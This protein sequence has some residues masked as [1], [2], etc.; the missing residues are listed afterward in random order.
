MKR[1]AVFTLAAAALVIFLSA[2]KSNLSA[3]ASAPSGP[4]RTI[5]P[6][7]TGRFGL[8]QIIDDYGHADDGSILG[9]LS[10]AQIQTEAPHYDSVWASFNPNAWN[11]SHRGMIVSRYTIPNEDNELIS[12]R[13]LVWWQKNRP[14]WV[15][16]A[17]DAR[18]NPTRASPW[19]GVGFSDVPLD[20]H[21]PAVVRYQAHQ[22]GD[23]MIAHGYN[24]LAV[25]NF[26]FANYMRAPN[27]LLGQG[28][29]RPGWYACGIY[30]DGRFVR[31]YGSAGSSDF[32]RADP[33]WITDL[34]NWIA[35]TRK[36]FDSDPKLV[37]HH[38]KVLVNHPILGDT[39]NS[40]EQQMLRSVDGVLIENGFTK[41]GQYVNPQSRSLPTLLRRTLSWMQA[42]QSAHTAVFVIDYFCKGGVTVSGAACSYDPS[43]LSPSQ[44]DWA[45]ATYAIANNGGAGVYIAPQ[46]GDNYSYRAEY[47]HVYGAP[48]GDVEQA[49]AV[50]TRRFQNGMAIVNASYRAQAVSLPTNHTYTDIEGRA[51][52]N[53][54]TVNGADGYM[55]LTSANGCL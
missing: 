41:Y 49:G 5:L 35:T 18:G 26:T 29:P 43:T 31:R 1:A 47:A 24:T 4:V 15:L 36:I 25:D 53:P 55:L 20:I 13:D 51:L 8:I 2:C 11:A 12:R 28:R 6:D 10:D 48:C 38:L 14:A 30:D 40:Y 32:G 33:A 27:P 46:G 50:Y 45:L 16:Y 52:S 42:A 34:L 3:A 17:C 7:T 21:N 23:Y 37:R 39:P 44:V 9:P 22:L 54:L 19:S